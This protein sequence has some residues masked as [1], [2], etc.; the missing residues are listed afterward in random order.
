MTIKRR[1]VSG[2]CRHIRH[3]YEIIVDAIEIFHI[4]L[5]GTQY[6]TYTYMYVHIFMYLDIK[7]LLK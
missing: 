5:S 6:A 2:M 3:A 4:D 1:I 7:N